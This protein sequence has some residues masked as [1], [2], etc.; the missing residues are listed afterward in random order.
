[1]IKSLTVKDFTVFSEAR[2]DLGALNIIHGENGA[3]KTHLLKLA[4]SVWST[5]RPETSAG[6][7]ERPTKKWLEPE[8]GRKLTA[9]FRPDKLGRLARRMP[10]TAKASVNVRF[11]DKSL[12]TK[13]EFHT[14][15]SSDV[16]VKSLPEAWAELAPVYLPTREALSVFPGFVSLYEGTRLPF[17]ETW[18]DLCQQLDAR[19]LQGPRPAAVQHMLDPLSLALGGELRLEKDRFYLYLPSG[20]MEIDLVAEG[21]RK[22]AMLAWL[23]ATQK[24]QSKGALFWD[25]PEA[26]LNPKLVKLVAPV[27]IGLARSGV[28]VFAATHSLFLMRELHVL[29]QGADKGVK[30]RFIGLHLNDG[31]VTVDQGD[32]LDDSGEISTLDETLEQSERYLALE[33]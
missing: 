23:V 15:S 27:L 20:R 29:L 2:F 17:D 13:F 26:N 25:E 16:T 12:N 6:A 5:L 19:L 24:L 9:V 28:Q 7:P 1:M 31:E 14:R 8:L 18:R 11:D 4:Y 30:T 33:G 22:L 3:G 21:V 10:G 32:T